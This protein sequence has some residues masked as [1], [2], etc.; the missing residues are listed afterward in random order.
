MSNYWYGF[1]S[2]C[3]V[4]QAPRVNEITMWV[5]PAL[6]FIGCGCACCPNEFQVP[7]IIGWTARPVPILLKCFILPAIQLQLTEVF[8]LQLSLDMDAMAGRWASVQLPAE[9]WTSSPRLYYAN[10]LEANCACA[11]SK[12][13]STALAWA[14]L[15]GGFRLVIFPTQHHAINFNAI[16]M[17]AID[18]RYR[19]NLAVSI[20]S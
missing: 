3:C 1:I 7:I 4:G 8:R 18:P 20:K 11:R 12:S 5:S 9:I 6:V 16:I 14:I 17:E 15:V 13:C 2:T 19:P 10:S